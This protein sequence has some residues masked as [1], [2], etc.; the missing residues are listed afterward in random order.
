MRR[1][2]GAIP[3]DVLDDMRAA[4][5]LLLARSGPTPDGFEWHMRRGARCEWVWTSPPA[6]VRGF[7]EGEAR[8]VG[9]AVQ[10]F[11]AVVA[12]PRSRA[13]AWHY[14][15]DTSEFHTMMLQV[16]GAADAGYTQFE[17]DD[18]PFGEGEYC[19]F[20]GL[21]VHRGTGNRTDTP[22]VFVYATF[23]TPEFVDANH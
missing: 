18:R 8:E 17:A 9:Y 12:P 15:S 21:T 2:Y 23:H 14:D 6:S 5:S 19:L 4:T 11:Y 22:R 13:Q 3:A 1:Q 16:A 7:V 20:D 10:R